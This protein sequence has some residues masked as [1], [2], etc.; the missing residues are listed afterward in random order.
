VLARRRQL[1]VVRLDGRGDDHHLGVL[2][3]LGRVSDGHVHAQRAQPP[4]VGVLRQVAALGVVAQVVQDL[5]D[6]RH[7]DAADADEVDRPGV[8]G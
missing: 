6:A 4:H 3:V 1:G 5:G 8:E 7:A 2:Q